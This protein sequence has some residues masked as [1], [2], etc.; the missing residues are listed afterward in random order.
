MTVYGLLLN[1]STLFDGVGTTA[2][3]YPAFEVAYV[4]AGP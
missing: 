3:V 4:D 1:A 2:Y